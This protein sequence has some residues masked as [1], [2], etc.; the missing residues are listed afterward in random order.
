MKILKWIFSFFVSLVAAISFIMLSVIL[1]V[2]ALAAC[3]V[4]LPAFL[5]FYLSCMFERRD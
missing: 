1:V 4:I 5:I 2:F 3:I